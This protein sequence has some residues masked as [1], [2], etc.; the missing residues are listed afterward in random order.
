MCSEGTER[1]RKNI[2]WLSRQKFYFQ[3][4]LGSDWSGSPSMIFLIPLS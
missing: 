3:N 2:S 4:N 1:S